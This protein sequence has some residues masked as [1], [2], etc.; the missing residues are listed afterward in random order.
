MAVKLLSRFFSKVPQ[1][2][3]PDKSPKP[4][5]R[6]KRVLFVLLT[7]CLVIGV[8]E[9]GARVLLS[10]GSQN[11][12]RLRNR[13][14]AVAAQQRDDGTPNEV[15]HPYLGWVVNPQGNPGRK[16]APL[17]FPGEADFLGKRKPGRFRVA[18]M[19][20]SVAQGMVETS[21][22]VLKTKLKNDPRFQNKTIEIIPLG[23]SGYKQP[24]QL[25]LLN[26]LLS[27]GAEYDAVINI[28][29]YNEIALHH[30][31]N[32]QAGVF[33]AYPRAWHARMMGVQD[34][35]RVERTFRLF[36]LKL[37]RIRLANWI[38]RRPYRYSALLNVYWSW[39]DNSLRHKF[40]DQQSE[41][42]RMKKEEGLGYH[43]TG[44]GELN[45]SEQETYERLADVWMWSS[46]QLEKLCE[47]N[48][49]LYL[50][51]LQ[52]NQYLENTKP[53]SRLE[54]EKYIVPDQGYGQSVVK[55]YPLLLKRG[56]KLREKGVPFHD[57]TDLFSKTAETVYSDR[58][59]HFNKKGY[60]MLAEK[61]ATEF[62]KQTAR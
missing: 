40:L 16:I 48:G 42:I 54:K 18:V 28:D 15:L 36:E 30:S 61:I 56:K 5:S 46:I 27:L 7:V 31:E 51:C 35:V 1:K 20:G 53:L 38:S 17:G 24:Q 19:G 22:D 45:G 43:L 32:G 13:Q 41:I 47:A 34:P 62:L 4:R 33:Y 49:M 55:G 59:C 8:L 3:S 39:R 23:M 44:P 29:G 26:Y 9:I 10:V 50:H 11:W 14:E 58:F 37:A 52:P 57:L 25:I 6:R 2:D 60:D 12:N 21:E